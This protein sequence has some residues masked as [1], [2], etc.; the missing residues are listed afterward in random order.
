M[1]HLIEL[2][3]T[4]R[5]GRMTQ[6]DERALVFNCANQLCNSGALNLILGQRR[7]DGCHRLIDR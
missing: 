7:L 3:P 1:G 2:F 4:A 6:P 5:P